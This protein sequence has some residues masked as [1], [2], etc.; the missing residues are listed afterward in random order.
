M[1]RNNMKI[2]AGVAVALITLLIVLQYGKT[3][4]VTGNE[5]LFPALREKVNDVTAVVI[6]RA[7]EEKPTVIRKTPDNWVVESRDNYP[8]DIGKLREL[9]L[10]LAD[11]KT[12]EQKT[13]NPD[14]YG[15]LG[16]SDPALDGSKGARLQISG[17][18]VDYDIV[19]GNVAQPGTRLVR[20]FAD[21][22]S[23]LVD[24]D[25]ALPDSAAGWMVK[26]IVD[27]QST[28]IQ[29]VTI[30]HPDGEE[31]RVSREAAEVT[32]FDVVDIPDGRELSYATVANGIA[33]ALATLTFD[34]VRKG[35][36]FEEKIA[37]ATFET[38]AG[39]RVV[40]LVGKENDESW[41]SL[42]ASS[43]DDAEGSAQS[44][45]ARV[46][47][48]QYKIADYK[49]NQLMRRWDDILKAEGEPE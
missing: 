40:V 6:T 8:A 24:K 33:G 3:G 13:S 29:A 12:I 16:V 21:S 26:D 18:E 14:L 11:A 1:N 45:N 42:I 41:I 49:V 15:Q 17:N 28:D 23:W 36:A 34:D 19:I 35:N 22:Q 2:L 32:D 37:T 4:A 44:I 27:L 46:E 47:G 38:F 48:W 9:L 20:K 25:P 43:D 30:T 10:Q 5:L 7:G 31:I 39:A